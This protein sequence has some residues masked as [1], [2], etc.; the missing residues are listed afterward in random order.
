MK[1]IFYY[2]DLLPFLSKEQAAIDKLKRN[3]E[4]FRQHAD[5][6]TLIWHPYTKTAEY[7]RLNN[8]SV[9]SDYQDI[10]DNYKLTAWGVLDDIPS[11]DRVR[12]ILLSCNAYYGDV[13]NFMYDAMDAGLPVM[14][15]NT[16]I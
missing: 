14:I 11:P 12:D 9:L 8:S 10:V 2:T 15:Q 3:L 5:K 7:L 16:D 6:I 13:S 1:K 4:V